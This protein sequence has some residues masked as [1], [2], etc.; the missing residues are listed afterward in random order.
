MKFEYVFEEK[1][2]PDA[3]SLKNHISIENFPVC[4]K[5]SI[6]DRFI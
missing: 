2:L 6:G 3:L 4:S 5:G 1:S